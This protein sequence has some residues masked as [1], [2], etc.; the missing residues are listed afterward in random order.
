MRMLSCKGGRLL[1]GGKVWLSS[2]STTVRPVMQQLLKGTTTRLI[3][4]RCCA[5]GA[6]SPS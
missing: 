2:L 3:F 4:R 1:H 6:L 5:S